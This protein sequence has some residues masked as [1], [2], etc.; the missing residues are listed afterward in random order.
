[1][2]DVSI[3]PYATP[4]AQT[5]AVAAAKDSAL[6]LISQLLV[7][8]GVSGKHFKEQLSIG[9]LKWTEAA[10]VAPHAKFNLR[11]VSDGVRQPNGPAS[12]NHEQ[13]WTRDWIIERL[14]AKKTWP[15]DELRI[16]LNTYGVACV[17]TVQEHALLGGVAGEGWDRYHKA[18]IRV[19]DREL[20][21]DL[22]LDQWQ[23]RRPRQSGRLPRPSA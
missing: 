17:V 18:G 5:A 12:I 16:C 3:V 7:L 2:P 4:Y 9:L 11:Y 21:Q 19:W 6:A 8:K 10:G 15:T 22:D 1:M 20:G 13:V 23:A 14:R